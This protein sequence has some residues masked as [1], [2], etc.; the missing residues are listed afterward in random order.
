MAELV[1][2]NAC[3]AAKMF[4][5]HCGLNFR[6]QNAELFQKGT[7][8]PLAAN[9][10]KSNHLCAFARR[11]ATEEVITVVS[12]LI[13]ELA[14]QTHAPIGKEVWS[15]TSLL[16]PDGKAGEK[17]KNILTDEVVAVVQS[18]SG[19]A[20][21]LADVLNKFPVALLQKVK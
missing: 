17:Y 6:H 14:N 3:E 11:D 5:I 15:E 13:V 16:L 1:K 19:A 12:R 7:Y 21:P 4:V 8:I 20:L 10:P 9:G 18:E 2:A